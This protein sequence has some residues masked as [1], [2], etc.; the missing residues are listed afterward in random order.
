MQHI[1]TLR[2]QNKI[3]VLKQV[4]HTATTSHVLERPVPLA[5]YAHSPHTEL[6]EPN[7]SH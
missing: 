4:E 7:Y 6:S 2:E 5:H 3:A 1:N